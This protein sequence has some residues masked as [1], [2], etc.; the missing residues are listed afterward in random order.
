MCVKIETWKRQ[1]RKNPVVK[2]NEGNASGSIL[3][4]KERLG[5]RKENGFS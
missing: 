5:E 4:A 1:Q 2:Q 3:S